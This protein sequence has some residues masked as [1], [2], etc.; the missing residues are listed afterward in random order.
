M[1]S[2]VTKILASA[3]GLFILWAGQKLKEKG[4]DTGDLTTESA[5]YGLQ[6]AAFITGVVYKIWLHY[7]PPPKGDGAA[8]D[9]ALWKG[10]QMIILLCLMPLLA[11]M[12]GCESLKNVSAAYV[13]A[14]RLTYEAIAPEYREYVANDPGLTPEQQQ[15]RYRTIDT[16]KLRWESGVRAQQA[17]TKPSK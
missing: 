17:T 12:A 6:A 1:L 8:S 11:A 3:I 9:P 14:D 16:W 15:R 7:Q 13:N 10:R 5:G 2:V 4:I